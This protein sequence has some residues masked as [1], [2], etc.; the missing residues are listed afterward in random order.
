MAKYLYHDTY[1]V[2]VEVYHD[3]YRI[4]DQEYDIQP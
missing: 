4:I 1:Q 3:T 2:S